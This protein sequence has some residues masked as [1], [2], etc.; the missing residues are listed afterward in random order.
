MGVAKFIEKLSRRIGLRYARALRD[1]IPQ[2][3]SLRIPQEVEGELR[4]MGNFGEAF[5]C[6]AGPIQPI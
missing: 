4:E 5:F 6:R 3:I 2:G 1:A